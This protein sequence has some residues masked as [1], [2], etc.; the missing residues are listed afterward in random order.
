MYLRWNEVNN[1]II[2]GNWLQF[3]SPIEHKAMQPISN[4][5]GSRIMSPTTGNHLSGLASILQPQGSNS[6]KGVAIG[7]DLGRSIHG[8]HMFNN[9]NSSHGAA[10][11]SHSLPEPT[12]GQYHGALSSFGQ[13]TSNGSSVETLSGPQFLW[14]N[15]S[16]YSEHTKPSP[17]S[18][19]SVGMPFTS[20][21]KGHGFPYSGQNGSFIG[22]SQHHLHHHVGSAPSVPFE[23]RLGFL[24]ESPETSFMNHVGYGGINV[25][26]NDGNYMV[27][28]GAS[29]NG[30]NTIPRNVSE[31]VQSNL[32]MRSSPRLSP[33]F[34]GNGPYPGLPPTALDGLTDRGRGRRL[35]NNGSQLD[36]KKQFLLDL[37]KIN[38]GEDARTTLMIKNIPNK[39][40]SIQAIIHIFLL[41]AFFYHISIGCLNH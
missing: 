22:S 4:S 29:V 1:T 18:R 39:Y 8:D 32:R 17:W 21:G 34:L 20:N 28:M 13:S 24:S 31:N 11:Q 7:K 6:I 15:S 40:E 2:S 12:F 5:P 37:D 9:T 36:S 35:E 3:S 41:D 23:R 38:S 27:N 33:V 10:F 30:S 26:H 19:S 25:A 14:G 16:L